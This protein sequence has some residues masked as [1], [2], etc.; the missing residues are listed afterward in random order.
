MSMGI[1]HCHTMQTLPVLAA[2]CVQHT[3]WSRAV[4][5]DLLHLNFAAVPS[6]VM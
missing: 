5:S 2:C 6:L 3:R 1:F 4:W